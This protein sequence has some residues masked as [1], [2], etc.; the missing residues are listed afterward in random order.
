MI[1]LNFKKGKIVIHPPIQ[2]IGLTVKD[3]PSIKNKSYY[4]IQD[5]L[6]KDN[7]LLDSEKTIIQTL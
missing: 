5:Q 2:T 6:W 7:N 1:L 3:L 4:T